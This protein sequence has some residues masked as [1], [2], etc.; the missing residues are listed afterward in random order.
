M[1]RIE[2]DLIE[3]DKLR[4]IA[5]RRREKRER[6]RLAEEAAEN[7]NLGSPSKV[8]GGKLSKKDEN[9]IGGLFG[10]LLGT[11]QKLGQAAL[12]FLLQIGGFIAI[13]ST[14]EWVADPANQ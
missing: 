13:K 7:K 5:D 3:N 14:L 6:D 8:K 2:I 10:G 9:K 1:E 4:E 12:N 11:L